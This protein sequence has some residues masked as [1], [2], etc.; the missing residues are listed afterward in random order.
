MERY[1]RVRGYRSVE[2]IGQVDRL[3]ETHNEDEKYPTDKDGDPYRRYRNHHRRVSNLSHSPSLIRYDCS[4]LPTFTACA[5]LPAR[6]KTCV[7]RSLCRYLRCL[8]VQINVFSVELPFSENWN[9]VK[10]LLRS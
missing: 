5:S 7:S 4:E 10:R 6:G 2:W 9:T 3:G 8:G 1:N